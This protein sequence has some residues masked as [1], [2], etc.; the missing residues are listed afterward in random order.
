[1]TP[2]TSGPGLSTTGIGTGREP[3]KQETSAQERT[4]H[5]VKL[6]PQ[7][8]RKV[9]AAGTPLLLFTSNGIVT[10]YTNVLWLFD[11]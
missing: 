6:L 1:M 11:Y 5:S 4:S 8:C 7:R 9:E 2:A 10:A 3:T